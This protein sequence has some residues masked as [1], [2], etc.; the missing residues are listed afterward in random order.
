MTIEEIMADIAQFTEERDWGQFHTHKDLA[1][2][3]SVEASELLEIFM[4]RTNEEIEEGI[5]G[6]EDAIL[7]EIA[8][9]MIYAL[10]MCQKMDCDPLAAIAWKMAKNRIKYPVEKAKGSNKKY[11]D[12]S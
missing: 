4:F 6:T 11:T 9:V 12:I 10:M 2:A 8:D 1:I 3:L 5:E 7:E